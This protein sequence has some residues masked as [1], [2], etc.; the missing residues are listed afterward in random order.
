MFILQPVSICKK[1]QNLSNSC[2]AGPTVVMNTDHVDWQFL[3]FAAFFAVGLVY[4][5][6]VNKARAAAAAQEKSQGSGAGEGGSTASKK[7]D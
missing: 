1:E 4:S 3:L 7:A 6:F 2:V 5:H